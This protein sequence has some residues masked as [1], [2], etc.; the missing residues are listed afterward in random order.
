VS[1]GGNFTPERA[2][3]WLPAVASVLFFCF[4]IDLNN[5]EV[6][7]ARKSVDK[8]AKRTVHNAFGCR[9]TG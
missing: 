9:R 1:S 5:K 4:Y 2:G 7:S 8:C 3:R 6:N